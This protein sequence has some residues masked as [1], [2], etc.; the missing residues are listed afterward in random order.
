MRVLFFFL[1]SAVYEAFD[2]VMRPLEPRGHRRTFN[3]EAGAW[4]ATTYVEPVPTELSPQSPTGFAVYV[5]S[6]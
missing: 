6:L 5:A 2:S 1:F 4:L 3:V